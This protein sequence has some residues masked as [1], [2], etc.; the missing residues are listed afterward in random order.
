MHLEALIDK[1]MVSMVNILK[2]TWTTLKVV[3]PGITRTHRW[4]QTRTDD[5][6]EFEPSKF[7]CIWPVYNIS[8]K[9]VPV[10]SEHIL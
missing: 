6:D 7:D 10:L 9:P 3:S 4:D 1:N 2:Y 8:I 5:P